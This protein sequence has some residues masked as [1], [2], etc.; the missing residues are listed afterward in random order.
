MVIDK[1]NMRNTPVRMEFSNLMSIFADVLS[2]SMNDNIAVF[3]HSNNS[4]AH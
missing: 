1:R 4:M 2:L 3:E